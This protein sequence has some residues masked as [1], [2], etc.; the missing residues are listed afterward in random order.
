MKARSRSWSTSEERRAIAAADTAQSTVVLDR[1]IRCKG[2]HADPAG[3]VGSAQIAV[4]I[5]AFNAAATVEETLQGF[6]LQDLPFDQWELVVVDDASTDN[7]SS[8]VR[9]FIES[10]LPQGALVVMSQNVGAARGRSVARAHTQ[11][12]FILFFD[13]DD[14]PTPDYLSAHLRAL[15]EADA[16]VM[17]FAVLDTGYFAHLG[18][19]HVVGGAVQKSTVNTVLGEV[20]FAT[21]GTVALPARLFDSVAGFDHA[22]LGCE[23]LD[24]SIRVWLSGTDLVKADGARCCYRQRSGLQQIYRQRVG[25]SSSHALLIKK[26]WSLINPWRYAY[27]QLRG[28]AQIP[29]QLVATGRNWFQGPEGKVLAIEQLGTLAGYAEGSWKHRIPV[30]LPWG[31]MLDPAAVA[32]AEPTDF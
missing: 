24:F 26:Y 15:R 16:D 2:R 10:H 23:D 7:T 32:A 9:E 25:Y 17:S 1:R 27:W 30:L 6:M 22:M 21:G 4:L 31:R 19:S 5:S 20:P 28:V 29:G 8:V 14:V 18:P 11:A 12:P 3:T 13:A